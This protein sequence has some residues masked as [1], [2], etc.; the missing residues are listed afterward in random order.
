M[1]EQNIIIKPIEFTN[2]LRIESKLEPNE[3]GIL[4]ASMYIQEENAEKYLEL[5]L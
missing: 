1:R 2:L 5:G 4:K 3:H